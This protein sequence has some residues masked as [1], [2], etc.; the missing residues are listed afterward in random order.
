MTRLIFWLAVVILGGW[1]NLSFGAKYK[2]PIYVQS[3]SVKV[4]YCYSAFNAI[5]VSVYP[6]SSFRLLRSHG[7]GTIEIR[8]PSALYELCAERLN[9]T[10][11][12]YRIKGREVYINIAPH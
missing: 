1:P 5:N 11:M 2:A 8:I 10:A 9:C 7:C 6:D 12:Q 4:D 3:I